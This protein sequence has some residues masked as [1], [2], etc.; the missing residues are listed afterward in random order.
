MKLEEKDLFLLAQCAIS[1][2]YQAGHIIAEESSNTHEVSYKEGRENLAAQVLTKVDLLSQVRVMQI[3]GPTCG[4][5]DLA[6]LSEESPDDGGRLEKDYFWCIDPLDGTL[7]F[8]NG[9]PGYSVSI[10]LVSK[11][12]IAQIGV[13]YDPLRKVLYHAIRGRGAYRNGVQWTDQSAASKGLDKL[14]LIADKSFSESDWFS[15]L[16]DGLKSEYHPLEVI[17]HGGGAMNAMWVLENTP[18]LYLKYPR[19]D[20]RGGSLWDYA[21]SNCIFNE[22]SDSCVATDYFGEPMALNYSES[23]FMNHNGILYASDRSVAE[24]GRSVGN[25]QTD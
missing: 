14:T 11:D 21:A 8:I 1:A 13:I 9:T 7:S 22:Y 24:K 4:T 16:V 25:Y 12:G 15:D 19:N 18:A 10:G 20:N 23:T 17:S 2:A 6:M 5:Y 3:L